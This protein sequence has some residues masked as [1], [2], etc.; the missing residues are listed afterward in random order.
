[1]PNQYEGTTMF[2]LVGAISIACSAIPAYAQ[3]YTSTA[4]LSDGTT[5]LVLEY[6]QDCGG[7]KGAALLDKGLMDIE[8]TCDVQTDAKSASANFK[9]RTINQPIT[10]FAVLSYLS[11][12]P[13][14]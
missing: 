2:Q 14:Q 1:M 9:T 5:L 3:G 6:S 4:K 12:M 8:Y 10:A 13:K 11:T 7:K